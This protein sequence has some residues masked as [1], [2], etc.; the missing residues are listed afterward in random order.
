MFFEN[1]NHSRESESKSL[2]DISKAMLTDNTSSIESLFNAI[3]KASVEISNAD[4]GFLI[5]NEENNFRTTQLE[6]GG[7]QLQRIRAQYHQK[8]RIMN[9]QNIHIRNDFLD[10]AR[11]HII[12]ILIN[13]VAD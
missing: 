8:S 3:L 1:F 6:N 7:K 4:A 9:S 12:N 11:S 5:L 2:N 10:P 13:Q